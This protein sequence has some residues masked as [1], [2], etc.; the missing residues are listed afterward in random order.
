MTRVNLVDPS[1][2]HRK[3]LVAELHELPRIFTL[4]RKYQDRDHEIPSTYTLGKGHIKFFY[5]KLN[6]LTER[7]ELLCNEMR[8]RGYKVNQI[9]KEAL[10]SGIN[11]SGQ[12]EYHPT[13]EDVALNAAR[14][15]ERTNPNWGK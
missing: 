4:Y 8:N 14:I 9:S 2:L 11:M 3:H 6:F 7:Y 13:S 12:I 15:K 10:L 5:N 1:T